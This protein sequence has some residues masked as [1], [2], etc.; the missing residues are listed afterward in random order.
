M[1]TWKVTWTWHDADPPHMFSCDIHAQRSRKREIG[2]TGLWIGWGMRKISAHIRAR[3]KHEALVYADMV[4][5]QV[6]DN[7]ISV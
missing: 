6:T 5:F 7:H 3:S 1:K 2:K 4:V